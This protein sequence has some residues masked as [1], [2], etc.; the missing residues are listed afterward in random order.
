MENEKEL[1]MLGL[2]WV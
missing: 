1:Y 2:N